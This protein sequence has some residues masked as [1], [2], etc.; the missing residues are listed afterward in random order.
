MDG[1]AKALEVLGLDR[2]PDPRYKVTDPHT[3]PSGKQLLNHK[4]AIQ[5]VDAIESAS[6]MRFV[7]DD[8]QIDQ[9]LDARLFHPQ[10]S[11][12]VMLRTDLPVPSGPKIAKVLGITGEATAENHYRWLWVEVRRFIT[13]LGATAI[14]PVLITRTNGANGTIPLLIASFKLDLRP[15]TGQT[16]DD[17]GANLALLGHR[18][19]E[20][21]LDEG[22][23]L[24]D[25][26]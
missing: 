26:K 3:V 25:V 14:S 22:E 11:R 4:K 19:P 10:Y 13:E 18:A 20:V 1:I 16:F 2:A 15:A 23:T 24:E 5:L 21:R 6:F 17:I 9:S 12:A 7:P 8:I